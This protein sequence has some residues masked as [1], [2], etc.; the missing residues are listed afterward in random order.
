LWKSQ[1]VVG[2]A[3]KPAK[4][5]ISIANMSQRPISLGLKFANPKKAENKH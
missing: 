4:P 5:N 2:I 3:G 1:G